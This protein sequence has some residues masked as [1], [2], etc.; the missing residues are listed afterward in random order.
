MVGRESKAKAKAKA[1]RKSTAASQ[2]IA[3]LPS[4]VRVTFA[5]VVWAMDGTRCHFLND[6]G[7]E[8]EEQSAALGITKVPKKYTASVIN[9]DTWLQECST[10]LRVG[11]W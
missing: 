11:I 6:D 9:R 1:T 5:Q 4:T 2:L 7:S 3:S 8:V 10:S